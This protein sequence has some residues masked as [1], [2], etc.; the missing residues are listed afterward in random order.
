MKNMKIAKPTL[1]AG[2]GIAAIVGLLVWRSRNETAPWFTLGGGAPPAAP[3]KATSPGGVTLPSGPLPAG[4]T[5]ATSYLSDAFFREI[6]NLA[7]YFRSRGASITGEDLLAVFL[8][9]SGVGPH[10]KNSIGCAGLNQICNLK[11]VGWTGTLAEYLALPGEQQLAF[12]RRYFDN[13]NRYPAIRD[14]GSLYLANFSPAFFDPPTAGIWQG[15]FP[16]MY[17]DPKRGG[18]GSLDRNYTAN[19]GVDFGNKG[20]IEI[21]DMAKFVRAAT[22]R[23][24]AKW[25][26][27]RMR[28]QRVTGIA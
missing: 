4:T 24:P 16:I 28:L 6:S 23:S 11:G 10:V 5:A 13:V 15:R 3:G 25:N 8:A 2:T 27:L 19:A 21:A 14:F 1:L 17:Q 20:F 22:V 7:I 26:E 9:E 18:T 12:V